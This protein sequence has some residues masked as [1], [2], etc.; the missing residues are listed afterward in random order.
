MIEKGVFHEIQQ[1][2]G[3]AYQ[4]RSSQDMGRYR[5]DRCNGDGGDVCGLCSKRDLSLWK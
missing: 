1:G 2:K 4:A 5:R 3:Q